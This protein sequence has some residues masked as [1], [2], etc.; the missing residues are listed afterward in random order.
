MSGT[1]LTTNPPDG[2]GQLLPLSPVQQ[3]QRG[4]VRIPKEIFKT[5]HHL[6][7]Q[8]DWMTARQ[9]S[10]TYSYGSLPELL[11]FFFYARR[12]GTFITR[13]LLKPREDLC[14]LDSSGLDGFVSFWIQTDRTFNNEAVKRLSSPQLMP[15]MNTNVRVMPSKCFDSLRKTRPIKYNPESW[16]AAPYNCRC[17]KK[18]GQIKPPNSL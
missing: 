6:S 13:T 11:L 14:I 8:A 9:Q 4:Q 2:T 3:C 17:G 16:G 1:S 5:Y 12:V 18:P 7:L 15:V 10:L